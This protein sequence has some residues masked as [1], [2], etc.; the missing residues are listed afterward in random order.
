MRVAFLTPAYITEKDF[1]GGLANYLYRV[2]QALNKR[3][4]DVEVFTASEHDEILVHDGVTVNRVRVDPKI[5]RVLNQLSLYKL[6]KTTYVLGLSYSLRKA[7][8]KR[9]RMKAFTV[10]QASSYLS[11]GLLSTLK[12]PAPIVSRVSSFEPLMSKYYKKPMRFGQRVRE[13]CELLALRRSDAVY[14]P[15][16]LLAGILREQAEIQVDVIRSP[17]FLDAQRSDDSVYRRCLSGKSYLLFFGTIG[18]LKGG[19]I[20]AKSLPALLSRYEDFHF[21]LCGSVK[22]GENGRET[23]LDEILRLAGA[24]GNR[25]IYLGVLRHPQLF[26]VVEKARAV[27][28]P[29]LIDNFPNTMLEAMALGKVVI[30]TRGTSYDEFIEDGVSGFL[31]DPGDVCQLQ[32]I[33]DRVFHMTKEERTAIGNHA[34]YKISSLSPEA[35]CRRLEL[36]FDQVVIDDKRRR[37]LIQFLE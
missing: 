21:V 5:L 14:A 9:H 27:V 7:L 12:R 3:G 8:K 16:E 34:A 24:N 37:G 10:I 18:L 25:V 20:L 13:F 28:L 6:T 15:S 26:P 22:E 1:H 29:S 23:V 35:T 2:T 19:R 31:V 4:H 11:V 30:G 32:C 17:L 33:M 36:Y